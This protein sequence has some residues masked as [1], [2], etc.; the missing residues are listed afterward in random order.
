MVGK[1][2]SLTESGGGEGREAKAEES[3]WGVGRAGG[4]CQPGAREKVMGGG[5]EWGRHVKDSSRGT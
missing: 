5:S 3:Q 1:E 2:A 4:V